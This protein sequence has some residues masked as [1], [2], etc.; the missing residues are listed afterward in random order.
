MRIL[1]LDDDQIRH[2]AFHRKYSEYN[3]LTHAY[4]VGEA[5]EA[6]RNEYFDQATL[7]HDLGEGNL[8]GY[9]FIVDMLGKIEPERWPREIFVHSRNTVG[10]LRM[11]ERLRDAG[12]TSRY[13]PFSS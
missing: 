5:I 7:D 1:V 12:I 4:T 9:D 2:D 13:V 10:G 11:T 8:D 3:D 6:M